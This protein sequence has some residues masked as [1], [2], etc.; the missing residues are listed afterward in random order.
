[1]LSY[2]VYLRSE[3]RVVMSVTISA[4]K[5]CSVRL[6]LQLFVGWL[7]SYL[8]YVCCLYLYCVVLLLGFFFVLLPVSLDC[9]FLISPS[10]FTNVPFD[11]E[12]TWWR[13]FEKRLVCT[14]LDIYAFID[15]FFYI[16]LRC[17]DFDFTIGPIYIYI[18]EKVVI[19][20]SINLFSNLPYK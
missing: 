2:Y 3:F 1:M 5:R 10:V 16:H 17:F 4:Y 7:M 14:K 13:L 15:V 19:K 18:S 6:Y 9:P 11:Y 8:C 20:I 12:C